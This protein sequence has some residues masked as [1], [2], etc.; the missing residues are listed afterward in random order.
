MGLDI[1]IPIGSLFV[2][3]GALLAGYGLWSSPAIYQRSLGINV[4]LWWGGALL[5][6][7]FA[8]LALAWRAASSRADP[9]GGN[10]ATQG[11]GAQDAT[12]R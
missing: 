11:S 7:G 2:I 8:M 4:N 10:R 3:L 1:R 6:F 9:R 5:V 12:A